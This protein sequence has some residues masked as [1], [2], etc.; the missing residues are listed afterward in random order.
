M[1]KTTEQALK[2]WYP[3]YHP[4]HFLLHHPLGKLVGE[5]GELLDD[6]MKHLYKPGYVFQP[7]D[8]LGD[9]WYY[10][11]ILA[12]Q[13]SHELRDSVDY[14]CVA[15]DQII[16][17]CIFV[18]SKWF[19]GTS[20]EPVSYKLNSIYSGIVQV[21]ERYSLTIDQLTASNWEKLKPGSERGEEWMKAL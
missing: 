3:E 8:E 21:A 4:L 12:H 20:L 16:A 10:L 5:L 13:S 11:R 18:S 9:A 14:T 1:N 15:I 2:T 7:E 17:Q 6:Y 19:C